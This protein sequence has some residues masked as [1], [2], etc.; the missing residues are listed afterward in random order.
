MVQVP[1]IGQNDLGNLSSVSVHVVNTKCDC[2]AKCKVSGEGAQLRNC[3]M[4]KRGRVPPIQ[5]NHSAVVYF[6][7]QNGEDNGSN[8]LKVSWL[9]IKECPST[10]GK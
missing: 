10:A 3:A 5:D 4:A 1:P 9:L 2:L 7:L 6:W 8:K